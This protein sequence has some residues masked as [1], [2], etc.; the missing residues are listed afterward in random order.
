MD[1]KE[2]N[3]LRAKHIYEARQKLDNLQERKREC[4]AGK[5]A[6]VV[7]TGSEDCAVWINEDAV[8]EGRYSIAL[9]HA[10]RYRSEGKAVYIASQ[11]RN[12]N[13]VRGTA[14]PLH[15][16]YD[17]DIAMCNEFIRN[18]EEAGKQSLP[19]PV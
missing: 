4:L 2:L 11:V 13:G 17:M 3:A 14:V 7:Y 19:T 15:K 16:A 12:G 9:A 10:T 5:P 8:K 1:T 18:L 6:W